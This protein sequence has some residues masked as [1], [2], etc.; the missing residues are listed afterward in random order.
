MSEARIDKWLWA[1]RLF[2]TRSIATSAC[3]NNRITINQT[4]AKPGRMVKP[5]DIVSVRKPPITYNLKVLKAAEQ[6]VGAKLVSEIYQD[7]I[8]LEQYEILKMNKISGF[9]DRA[10]GTGRPTKKDRRAMEAFVRPAL[11]GLNLDEED[12][13]D[14]LEE[15]LHDI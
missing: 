8:P 1:A 9:V 12:T 14:D 11:L 7:Q 15:Y 2:K 6:R 4:S 5:G 3:K 13:D 10:R